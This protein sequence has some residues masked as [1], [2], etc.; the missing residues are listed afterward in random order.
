MTFEEGKRPLRMNANNCWTILFA[1]AVSVR[2]H[3]DKKK[4]KK[5]IHNPYC[6]R[7]QRND[8]FIKRYNVLMLTFI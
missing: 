5:Q 7:N 4:M 2:R 8:N 6:N 1:V 3:I